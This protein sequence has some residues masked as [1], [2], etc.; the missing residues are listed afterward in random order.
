MTTVTAKAK[1]ALVTGADSGIGRVTARELATRI[2]GTDATAYAVHPGI[3][4]TDIRRSLSCP[5]AALFKRLMV[6]PEE[7]CSHQPLLR[8]RA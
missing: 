4:A 1:V 7:V 6:T 5:L 2:A 3:V 8:H